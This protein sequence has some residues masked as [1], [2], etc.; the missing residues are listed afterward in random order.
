M[1]RI[2][3]APEGTVNKSTIEEFRNFLN[4]LPKDYLL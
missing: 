2:L 4:Y 3:E 1:E